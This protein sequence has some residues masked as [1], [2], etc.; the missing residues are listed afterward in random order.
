M[1]SIL[2]GSDEPTPI[3]RARATPGVSLA[4]LTST[5]LAQGT[6]GISQTLNAYVTQE[7]ERRLASEL[8]ERQRLEAEVERIGAQVTELTTQLETAR[9]ERAGVD[10]ELAAERETRRGL[11]ERAAAQEER[12]RESG[13][14]YLRGQ[15]A[16]HAKLEQLLKRPIPA[17]AQPA[18]APVALPVEFPTYDIEIHRD[19]A[20]IARGFRLKP[21]K[22]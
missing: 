4:E 13:D 16:T 14:T 15:V 17:P 22:E 9:T 18:P 7:V 6:G 2:T 11:E 8:T 3:R 12:I 21:T 19:G 5:L 20:G 10:G 1:K